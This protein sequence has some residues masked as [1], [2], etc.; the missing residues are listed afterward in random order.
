MIR[1]AKFFSVKSS[2]ENKIFIDCSAESTKVETNLGWDRVM[3]S[4]V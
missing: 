2:Q 1:E 3:V 4:A